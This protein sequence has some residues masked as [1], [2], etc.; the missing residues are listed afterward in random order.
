MLTP[1]PLREMR[2]KG[3]YINHRKVD[4]SMGIKIC[5]TGLE[6]ALAGASLRVCNDPEELEDVKEEVEDEFEEMVNAFEKEDLGVYVQASTLGSLEALLAFLK[7]MNI[8]VFQANIGVVHKK[9]VKK[10]AIMRDKGKPEYAVI[11]AF[12]VKVQKIDENE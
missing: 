11:L 4:T 12:D 5:A 1:Q 3:D 10:A 8:P 6:H 7:S 2:V 9:D